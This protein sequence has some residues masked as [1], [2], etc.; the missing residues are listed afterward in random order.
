[1]FLASLIVFPTHLSEFPW[2]R[3]CATHAPPSIALLA[4]LSQ[5]FKLIVVHAWLR[6]QGLLITFSEDF[7]MSAWDVHSLDRL[8]I[9]HFSTA[10]VN[11]LL[12]DKTELWVTF[13][14]TTL[15]VLDAFNGVCVWR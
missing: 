3:G 15:L 12:I 8:W 6:G 11:M 14:D 10:V 4:H 5:G 13:A 1:V 9:R 7:V 2:Q